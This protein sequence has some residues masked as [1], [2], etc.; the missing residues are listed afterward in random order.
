MRIDGERVRR[1]RWIHAPACVVQ[2]EVDAVIPVDDPTEPCFEPEVVEF[3][4]EVHEHA[5]IGDIEWLKTVGKVFV[6]TAA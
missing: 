3:L 5:Q 2:V 6:P 4:R 1:T